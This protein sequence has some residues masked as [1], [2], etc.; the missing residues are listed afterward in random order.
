MYKSKKK[1]VVT[2]S[3]LPRDG[4]KG[5]KPLD[6]KKPLRSSNDPIPNP[7]PNYKPPIGKNKK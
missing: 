4:R 1:V 5:N 3:R 7:N 2:N 6:V